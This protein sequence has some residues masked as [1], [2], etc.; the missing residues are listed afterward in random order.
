MSRRR[1]GWGA[2][3]PNSSKVTMPDREPPRPV[4]AGTNCSSNFTATGGDAGQRRA[5]FTSQNDAWRGRGDRKDRRGEGEIRRGGETGSGGRD[6]G[7]RVRVRRRQ[8]RGGNRS[9]GRIGGVGQSVRRVG[10]V[11]RG[12]DAVVS[13]NGF[14]RRIEHRRGG[15]AGAGRGAC[16]FRAI[17]THEEQREEKTARGPCDEN[18]EA[19]NSAAGRAMR[20]GGDQSLRAAE[21][22]VVAIG[23]A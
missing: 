9:S 17:K 16:G 6:N 8:V 21:N 2:G 7:G 5:E 22:R 12:G 15:A 20:S 13:E 1:G 11:E 19:R 4:R 18:G 23:G 14:G 3:G 10:R